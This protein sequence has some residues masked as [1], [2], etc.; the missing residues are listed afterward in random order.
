MMVT[1]KKK[2]KAAPLASRVRL[3]REEKSWTQAELAAKAGTTEAKIEKIENG[4]NVHPG[5]IEAIAEALD[6]SPWWLMFGVN[7]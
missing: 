2:S 6:V 3:K 1:S 5:D 7:R 4:K